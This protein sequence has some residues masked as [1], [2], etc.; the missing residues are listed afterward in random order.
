M[1]IL[2]LLYAVVICI[3]SKS[4][5]RELLRQSVTKL[6]AYVSELKPHVLKFWRPGPKGRKNG[7]EISLDGCLFS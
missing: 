7:G 5:F 3:C 1:M 6:S 2:I 4:A